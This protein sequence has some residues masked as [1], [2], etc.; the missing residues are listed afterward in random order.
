MNTELGTTY[1]AGRKAAELYLLSD[2]KYDPWLWS[3]KT[4][5]EIPTGEWSSGFAEALNL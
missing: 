3:W 1:E 4:Y 2:S 5:R